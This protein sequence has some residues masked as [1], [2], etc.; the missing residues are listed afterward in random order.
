MAKKKAKWLEGSNLSIL[1]AIKAALT[2]EEVTEKEITKAVK[3][4]EEL[5]ERAAVDEAE[6][7][8]M[9]LLAKA[10]SYSVKANE[11]IDEAGALYQ[12]DLEAAGIAADTTDEDAEEDT[13]KEESKSKKKSKKAKK[14]EKV[15]ESDDP[16]GEDHDDLQGLSKKALR[17]LAKEKG[18]KTNKKMEKDEIIALIKEAE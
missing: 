11:L 16:D 1:E 15:E 6:P 5:S 2:A 8:V 18:I 12:A 9:G 17:E 7:T 4:V 14:T 10:S 3:G 13:D